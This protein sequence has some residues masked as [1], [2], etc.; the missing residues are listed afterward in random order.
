LA[1][2]VVVK[3]IIQISRGILRDQ[4]MRRSTMFYVMLIALVML[5]AGSAL[6]DHWLRENVWL[7]LLWWGLCAWLT[8]L[9]VLLALFDLL[10][11]RTAARRERRR[12][13]NQLLREEPSDIDDA[14]SP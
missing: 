12:L 7:F 8:L 10:L 13:A 9:A 2:R 14:D 11:V 3:F 6:I 4:R 1:A 5:F